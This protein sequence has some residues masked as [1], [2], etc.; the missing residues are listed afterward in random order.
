MIITQLYRV[1]G[2]YMDMPTI[3]ETGLITNEESEINALRKDEVEGLE[4]QRIPNRSG[5]VVKR[6]DGNTAIP[7][8]NIRDESIG[9]YKSCVQLGATEFSQAFPAQPLG[10]F[11]GKRILAYRR[12]WLQLER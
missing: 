7:L 8:N 1:T 12:T 11:N 9:E 10:P 4:I 5:L 3:E 2:T 6:L